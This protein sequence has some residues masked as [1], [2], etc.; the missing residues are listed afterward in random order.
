MVEK[1]LRTKCYFVFYDFITN[2]INVNNS[3]VTNP[4]Y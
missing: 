1:K 3:N 2:T 4:D